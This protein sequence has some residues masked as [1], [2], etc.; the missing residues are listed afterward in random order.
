M[1]RGD[2]S[3]TARPRSPPRPHV[4]AALAFALLVF[5]YLWP[6]L[7]GGR[8]LSPLALLYY[9]APWQGHQPP[10]FQR[11]VNDVLTDV[12]QAIYPWRLWVRDLIRGGTFP[13][14]NPHVLAG[15]PFFALPETGLFTPFSLPLWLLPLNYGIGLGA[16][17]KL[18]AGG[19][20]TYLLVRQLGLSLLPGLL[21][22]IS[23]AFCSLNI[24]WLTHETLPAVAVMVPWMLLAIERILAR[25][26]LGG[27]LALALATAFALGGGHPG[28]QVHATAAAGLYAALRAAALPRR[29]LARR[30]RP[31]ALVAAGLGLGALL[32]AVTLVPE[33]LV[34]HGTVGTLARKGGQGTLPGEQ[35]PLAAIRTVLFPDWW[36]R[37]TGTQ[38]SHVLVNYN[39]G[40]FYAG[41]VATLL[42]C[43]GLVSPGGWRRKAPFALFAVLGLAIPL[44][45]PLLFG[46][47]EHLPALELV[48]NQRLHFLFELGTAVLAAFGLQALLDR[49][50]GDRR[51][52]AVVLAVA[53][54]P[55][56]VAFATAGSG[57]DLG[58]LPARVLGGAASHSDAALAMTSVGWFVVFALGVT[59]ALAAGRLWPGR[60]VAIA[61][62]L[63]L[64]AVGDM[65]HFAH[66]YQPMG[67]AS[68]VIPPRTATVAYLQRHAH[69]G[70]FV[71]VDQALPNDWGMAY[72]LDDVRGYDPPLPSLRYFHLW[73]AVEPDQQ[74]WQRLGVT[75]LTPTGVRVLS[76]LGVRY[77]VFEPEAQ[78]PGGAD[79]ALR[80]LRR[81]H[82]D[83]D[84]VVYG[85]R[86]AAPRALVASRVLLAADE[87]GSVATLSAARF[88]P[89]GDA[90]VERD[91]PGA[92]A[93]AS[94][95]PVHGRVALAGERDAQVTLRAT[96][97]RRGLVV[98]DDQLA[99]G[100]TVRV[101]DH[102][103]R[104]LRVDDVMRGV[105]VGPGSHRIVWSYRVPGLALGLVLSAF[106]LVLLLAGA[107]LVGVRALRSR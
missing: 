104:A 1:P 99:P 105:V 8:I 14:W 97:D 3:R 89:R 72:R 95:G 39:E 63:V 48:Q 35:M 73:Q 41:V 16:A 12:P 13:A 102:P 26:R 61:A 43:I 92:A 52:I 101:D 5:A 2:R 75:E 4:W 34:S 80:A 81:V 76:V 100:W 23:F 15:A 82:A 33:L 9:Y 22:G 85:N 11:Y 90:V 55:V 79:P 60:V 25:E 20:G 38:A 77:L 32:M 86:R 54:I 84:A 64:L 53:A 50:A 46:F 59:V 7:V 47:V 30:L 68:T 6:V 18:W 87:T 98:L 67:P 56:A 106:A 94:A 45:A 51:R 44:R 70:R 37:P 49:P 78:P 71:G 29:P 28:M 31:L 40:T 24:T 107:A 27:A 91:Q 103:A 19:F 65:L 57:A 36:G 66:G 17:L 96:L 74:S 42:G 58:G 10:G 62:V 88:D 69:D 21:A 93:L 83:R